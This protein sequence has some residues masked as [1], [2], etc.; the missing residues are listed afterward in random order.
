MTTDIEMTTTK[1][2][3]KD[4]QR[5]VTTYMFQKLEDSI[6]MLRTDRNDQ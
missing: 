3:N 6:N 2:V 4:I 1:L 5:V